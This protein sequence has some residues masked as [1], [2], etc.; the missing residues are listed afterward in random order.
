[1]R[2]RILNSFSDYN[3]MF[4]AFRFFVISACVCLASFSLAQSFVD[5]TPASGVYGQP[6]D[7]TQRE[8][9]VPREDETVT[10]YFRVGYQFTYSSV[11]VYYTT[12]G[13]TPAGNIGFG[14]G[15]TQVLNSFASQVQFLANE[16]TGSGVVDWWKATLP[17]NTRAYGTR[18]RYFIQAWGGTTS[19]QTGLFEFTNKIAW[20]GQGS[21]YANHS[22]GYPPVH[23]WKEEAV[24]GNGYINT[25]LDQNG[26]LYDVY[27]PSA[28]AVEGVAAK[29]EGYVDGLDTFPPGLPL[30]SRGQ[31]N[32]N[33]AF[34]GIRW[35]GKTYW[36]TNE[37][38]GDYTNWTHEY[39]ADTQ[40]V[41]TTSKLVANSANFDVQQY[42][43]APIGITYPNDTSG[44]PNRGI[45]IKRLLIT[46]N[47]GSS[48]SLNVYFYMNPALNGGD[49]Y[50]AMFTDASR[51]AMCAYDNT[52]RFTSSSG[53]YNPTSFSNMAKNVSLYL[54]A[55]M[56]TTNTVGGSTGTVAPDSWRDTSS[57]NSEGWIGQRVTIAAGATKEVDIAVVGGFDNYAGASGTYNAQIA[58]ALTWFQAGN[59]ND[60]MTS[61]NTYWQNWLA[62]G[63]TVDFPDDKYDATYKR[64]LLATAL[65]LDGKSGAVVAGMHNGAYMYCWP[66]DA[67]WAAVT[68]ARTGHFPESS[69]VFKFL[70]ETAF[71]SNESWGKGFFYQKYSTDGYQVWSAPQ[72]DETAVV[73]WGVKL[74]FDCTNDTGFL[75]TN[76]TM[77]KDS[78]K[79]SSEDSAV[80]TR[81][82]YDDT[83]NL[84][85]T[86]NL[87]ED[88]F[89]LLVFSNANCVRGLY[90][91][92]SIASRLGYGSD[93]TA[94]NSRAALMLQGVKDR[95][96]W[97]GENTD[98][99]LLGPVYPFNILPAT[100]PLMVTAVNRMNGVA[101]DRFG[102]NHPIVNTSG[103]FTGLVNR[104]WGD[105]YWNGGPWWLSTMW[106]GM[107]YLE[108]SNSTA[109]YGDID[110]H[111][112]RIDRTMDYLGKVGFGAEQ[113]APSNSLLY[114]GQSDFRLQ[115]AWPN[116]WESMS[117]YVDSIAAFL[118]FTP[119][120]SANTLR[121]AP[122]LPSTWKTMTFSNIKL[123]SHQ[124]D[125]TA[126]ESRLY[127]SQVIT[128][129][130][131]AAANLATVVRIP[132]G[133]SVT[134]VTVNGVNAPYTFES[135]PRRVLVNA[136]L[137]T[138]ANAKTTVMVLTRPATNGGGTKPTNPGGSTQSGK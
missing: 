82:Y 23:F 120:A 61:S 78:A 4:K 119:D 71:R 127:C 114:G 99:S 73:P 22:V 47:T 122:R 43:F 72:V 44:N 113:M 9:E 48:Q 77:V 84:M 31:L 5:H 54:A 62:S 28:G 30:G 10:I 49:S 108:R 116:A 15:T 21:A 70:R 111:K 92:A 129:R 80:D 39:V 13:S 110:N 105:T 7:I 46:N 25:M 57:D 112:Y 96:A 20:P 126:T 124:F 37:A 88:Q 2:I 12:D 11:A 24:A 79:A 45:H 133:A 90:D 14:S 63:M 38:G 60:A 94:F 1:M 123:G 53:E 51:G 27:Y 75:A 109:G 65:H 130:T 56:K 117:F 136:A 19:Q 64:G 83:Y 93:A 121:I 131:G 87:W 8:P 132:S 68:L 58:N 103:E 41:K 52:F 16:N 98:I 26:S 97:N 134:G 100:D 115:A 34:A 35:S 66:R 137:A 6:S 55:A 118:G 50:D 76:Y 104:Y 29:N 17:A 33:A 74:Y 59:M 95:L 91:A 107:Y 89:G 36:L 81:L 102:N 18:L 67:V 40:T 125:L 128:N 32:L 86:M 106:Y 85:N 138:G 42:D 135:G 101:N 69:N 3:A